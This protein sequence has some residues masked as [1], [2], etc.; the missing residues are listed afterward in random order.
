MNLR[1][2]ALI[3]AATASI[4]ACAAGPSSQADLD[5][6]HRPPTPSQV[7]DTPEDGSDQRLI[8]KSGEGEQLNV[9][10]FIR[11][12]QDWINTY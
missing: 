7:A 5:Y 11:D 2:V 1:R 10:W 3:A 12:A 6:R 8:L 9:P 4:T